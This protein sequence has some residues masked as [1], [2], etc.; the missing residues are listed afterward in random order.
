MRLCTTTF[1]TD[2]EC[3][4]IWFTFNWW[5]RW[6]YWTN[7]CCCC[8]CCIILVL[9]WT[10]RLYFYCRIEFLLQFCNCVCVS[11]C[12]VRPCVLCVCECLCRVLTIEPPMRYYQEH[13]RLF[14]VA[15]FFWM[16]CH[17]LFTRCRWFVSQRVSECLGF[18]RL[19]WERERK[20]RAEQVVK[21]FSFI[22]NWFSS[23]ESNR[24]LSIDA[25]SFSPCFCSVPHIRVLSLSLSSPRSPTFKIVRIV[26]SGNPNK[27]RIIFI[28]CSCINILRDERWCFPAIVVGHFPISL[29]TER[30]N[31]G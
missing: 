1:N 6:L 15:Q 28:F 19:G 3:K 27:Q 16:P 30:T 21:L 25:V 24:P 12:N 11:V 26:C 17:S 13:N 23:V 7:C 18:C 8:C 9:Y 5:W 10:M 22:K 29:H 31:T 20:R 14:S 2:D 4:C